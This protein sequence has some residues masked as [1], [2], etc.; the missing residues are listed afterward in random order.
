MHSNLRGHD[1]IVQTVYLWHHTYNNIGLV[2]H[3]KGDY[4]NALENF[5]KKLSIELKTL[6]ESDSDTAITHN[7]LR[8]VYK[9]KGDYD[10]ALEYHFKSP[11]VELK[12]CGENHPDVGSSY[13]N[14]GSVCKEKREYYNALE[15]YTKS[16]F[17][18]N[19]RFRWES[20]LCCFLPQ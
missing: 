7:N 1:F 6:G 11:T 18:P 15:Y 10:N 19:Q 12:T 13:N 8:L 14:I 3:S 20:S 16:L 2:Y 17:H 5:T 4:D 9:A